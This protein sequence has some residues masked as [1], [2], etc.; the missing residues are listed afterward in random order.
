MNA[1]SVGLSAAARDPSCLN[2]VGTRCLP[3]GFVCVFQFKF[4]GM[5]CCASFVACMHVIPVQCV[6]NFVQKRIFAILVFVVWDVF[7]LVP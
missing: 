3:E 1:E 7:R 4:V 2:E 6:C 5:P